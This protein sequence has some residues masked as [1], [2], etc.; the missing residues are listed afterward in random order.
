MFEKNI[1]WRE[2]YE[3]VIFWLVLVSGFTGFRVWLRFLVCVRVYVRVY[4]KVFTTVF[5][6]RGVIFL[7]G[8]RLWFGGLRFRVRELGRDSFRYRQNAA[9][10]KG[11]G[12]FARVAR[13]VVSHY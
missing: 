2:F 11:S 12:R 1:L 3:V 13:Q 7:F 10:V 9:G 6:L 5:R 4:R 8:V